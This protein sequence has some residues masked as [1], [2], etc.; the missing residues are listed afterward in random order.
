M[1]SPLF[2]ILARTLTASTLAEEATLETAAHGTVR[3]WAAFVRREVTVDTGDGKLPMLTAEP[4]ASI[5]EADAPGTDVGDLVYVSGALHSVRSPLADG[6]EMLKLSNP[7]LKAVDLGEEAVDAA[8]VGDPDGTAPVVAIAASGVLRR[9]NLVTID[10]DRYR[11]GTP[12]DW[13][14]GGLRRYVLTPA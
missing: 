2:A 12:T 9:S 5:A 14:A 11:V 3:T 7:K 1:T 4:I 6:G 10:G 8:V 13:P